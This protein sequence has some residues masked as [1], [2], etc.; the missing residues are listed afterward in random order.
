MLRITQKVKKVQ[1]TFVIFRERKHEINR[2][3]LRFLLP[4]Y[5]YKYL[6]LSEGIY[7][8]IIRQFI[9]LSLSIIFQHSML[10]T[11]Y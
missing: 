8:R 6:V 7:E 11:L 1:F 2:W 3:K 9:D 10:R 4:A 5:P